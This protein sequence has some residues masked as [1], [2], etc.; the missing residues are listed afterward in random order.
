VLLYQMVLGTR[1]PTPAQFTRADMHRDGQ[2]NAA[3][4]LLLQKKLLQ[5]ALGIPERIAVSDVGQPRTVVQASG[6]SLIA[7][8]LNA[9]VS[10]PTLQTGHKQSFLAILRQEVQ[11][12]KHDPRRPGLSVFST[13]QRPG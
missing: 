7:D 5:A 10:F 13:R 8:W 6:N 3:D 2:L 1:T 4:I 9:L 11:M 12:K